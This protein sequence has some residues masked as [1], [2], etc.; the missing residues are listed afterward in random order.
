MEL[1]VDLEQVQVIWSHE[2]DC[3]CV[4]KRFLGNAV[5]IYT[6]TITEGTPVSSFL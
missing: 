1:A 4:V 3:R 5:Q 6:V 2:S